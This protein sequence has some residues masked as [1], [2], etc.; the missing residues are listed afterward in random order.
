MRTFKFKLLTS[1]A[2]FPLETDV[3]NMSELRSLIRSNSELLRKFDV[4]PGSDL[5]ELNLIDR[6]TRTS[7]QLD[8]AVLPTTDT[9]FFVSFTKSK[10]G[11]YIPGMYDNLEEHSFSKLKE[12]AAFLNEMYDADIKGGNKTQLIVNLH[13]FYTEKVFEEDENKEDEFF[14][15]GLSDRLRLCSSIILDTADRIDS[16][17]EIDPGD[18]LVEGVTVSQLENESV[19]IYRALEK[20]GLVK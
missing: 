6:A 4:N 15:L 9:I 13:D 7:Y 20:L 10:G 5:S 14:E 18:E 12:L 19:E 3:Y 17:E 2:L 11:A 8:E 16:G 1:N